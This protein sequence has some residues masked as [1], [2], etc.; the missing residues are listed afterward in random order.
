LSPVLVVLLTAGALAPA[1]ALADWNTAV[2]RDAARRGLSPQ[3]G[4]TDPA[5]LW[6]G[7]RPSVIAQHGAAAGD[8][9][10]VNRI[11]NFNIPDGTLLVAHDLQTGAELWAVHLPYDPENPGHREK[12]MAIRDGQVYA[13]RGGD[14]RLDYVYALDPADGSII[15]RSEHKVDESTTESP[16]FAENGDL[17]VGNFNSL[18]RISRVDGTTVWN[19]PRT[20]PTTDGCSAAVAGNR[21]YIWEASPTGPKVTAFDVTTGGRSHSSLAIGG[22]FIQQ[23]G[24]LVGPD[25]TVYAPR[26]QNNPNTDFFV[27]LEDLGASFAERWRVPLGYVP[28][29]SFSIGPD[30]TVYTYTPA[31]EIV[32]LDPATGI[33]INTS[34]VI[35]ADFPMQPRMAI[36]AEGKVF[37]TNGGFGQG[38]LFSFNADLTLRWTQNVTNVNLGGP[39]IGQTGILVVCGVGTDVRAYRTDVVSVVDS[40][41]AAGAR[42]GLVRLGQNL[43]NPFNPTTE[44]GFELSQAAMVTLEVFDVQGKRV[45]AL[46][47]GEARGAG[48]HRVRWD[49]RDER[50]TP[51]AA[52]S[53]FYR[54]EAGGEVESRKMLLVK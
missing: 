7:S 33:P 4:P 41:F 28:F 20:C 19:V 35:P 47:P 1:S 37:V 30:G 54:L 24:L 50:G 27:A 22:G 12:V 36:D 3:V 29:A 9:L 11:A 10:V 23:L 44:I 25:G 34:M 18:R 15:W 51:A 39:V 48:R 21:A 13:T 31:R 8:L 45:Q 32:R 46:I 14:T 40:P 5:V 2:G 38:R 43:P 53:Y 26:T 16:A 52:G 6:Q 49:G 42:V 17:I